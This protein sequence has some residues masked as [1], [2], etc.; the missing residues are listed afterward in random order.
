MLL[1]TVVSSVFGANC[2]VVAPG[3]GA[4]CV[5]VD[6]G[7]GVAPAVREVVQRH[8]LRPVAVLATHGHADHTWDAAALS[9]AYKVPLRLHEADAYRLAD[10]LSALPPASAALT[11]ALVANGFDPS[12]YQ[13]PDRVETF[14]GG[15]PVVAADLPDLPV[16]A[17]PAPGHTEGSTLY[18]LDDTPAGE[19]QVI[20]WAA[21]GSGPEEVART[22]LTGDVVFA[23]T[24]GRTDLPGGDET[25]M[26]WTLRDV[27][28]SL[29]A[30]SLLLP[31]HGPA[32]TVAVERV[33]NPFL[34]PPT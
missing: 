23:G 1:V 28:G 25:R 20:G 6:P 21:A 11:G 16:R 15:E 33:R 32:T 29:P 10:P 13:R 12:A 31:G 14:S 5:V 3:V 17:L 7:A 34:R 19:S 4:P 8:A 30:D 9:T 27:V 18:R 26:A 24:I 2:Y 22:V